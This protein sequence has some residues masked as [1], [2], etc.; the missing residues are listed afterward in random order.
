MPLRKNADHE[1]LEN[2]LVWDRGLNF[3]IMLSDIDD[4]LALSEH[5]IDAQLLL[6]EQHIGWRELDN[7]LQNAD[8]ARSYKDFLLKSAKHRFTVALPMQIRYAALGAMTGAVEWA[9]HFFQRS[10]KPRLPKNLRNPRSTSALSLLEHFDMTMSLGKAIVLTDYRNLVEVR[11]AI[12]HGGGI[13]HSHD[14]PNVL[15]KAVE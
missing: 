15:K 2:I 6:E 12:L 10:W 7:D 14:R 5:S 11:H 1:A 4:F 8:L 13:I 9:A 3:I